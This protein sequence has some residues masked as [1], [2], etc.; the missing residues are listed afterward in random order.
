[1]SQAKGFAANAEPLTRLANSLPPFPYWPSLKG[2][3]KADWDHLLATERPLLDEALLSL[4]RIRLENDN[5][6]PAERGLR[7]LRVH[8]W[9]TFIGVVV[10]AALGAAVVLFH[11]IF[12][13]P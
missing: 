9:K 12:K 13:K 8:A 3:V 7:E 10:T 4:H 11:R 2:M 1:L 5:Y 6:S